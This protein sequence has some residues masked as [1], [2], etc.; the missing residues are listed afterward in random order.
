MIYI[1]NGPA[2]RAA[3]FSA[4]KPYWIGSGSFVRMQNFSTR[5]PAPSASTRTA[6]EIMAKRHT[7]TIR[8]TDK[9]KR[10][11]METKRDAAR[12]ASKKMTEM[13][14]KNASAPQRGAE[15]VQSRAALNCRA[16]PSDGEP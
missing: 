11:K 15:N 5:S 13:Q 9:S 10:A 3:P 8:H 14:P 6:A 7:C 16:F 2:K 12:A 1:K 4:S